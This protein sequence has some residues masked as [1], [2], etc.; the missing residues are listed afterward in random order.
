MSLD[1][2]LTAPYG[3]LAFLP[4]TQLQILSPT[5]LNSCSEFRAH[6]GIHTEQERSM[7]S[8]SGDALKQRQG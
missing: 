7:P 3:N 6:F 8:D 5:D 2:L 4:H 1:F